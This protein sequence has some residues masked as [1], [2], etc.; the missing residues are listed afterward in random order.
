[1]NA[2]CPEANGNFLRGRKETQGRYREGGA[3][4]TRKAAGNEL[5]RGVKIG[6]VPWERGRPVRS[7]SN[8]C[9]RDARAPRVLLWP[10]EDAS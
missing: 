3:G 2:G 1:M 9:G 8:V 4:V 10:G 5:Q 7:S 6:N